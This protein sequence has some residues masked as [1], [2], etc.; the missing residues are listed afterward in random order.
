MYANSKGY[1]ILYALQAVKNTFVLFPQKIV[2]ETENRLFQKIVNETESRLPCLDKSIH[3][4]SQ[5]WK[6]NIFSKI[7]YSMCN[8]IF[9]NRHLKCGL[10]NALVI[11]EAAVL[12]VI[13]QWF[14]IWKIVPWIGL[15]TYNNICIVTLSIILSQVGWPCVTKKAIHIG[16]KTN[17]KI[18]MQPN[19]FFFKD[20]S[21]S[22]QITI[23]CIQWDH[24]LRLCISKR[25]KTSKSVYFE[26]LP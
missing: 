2:Y 19:I 9:S 16:L 11:F 21:C 17:S 15:N 12:R 24:F 25:V 10:H 14:C 20:T 22:F 18:E 26:I 13:K 3:C 8:P 7:S 5:S 1:L 23:L 6:I 4:R